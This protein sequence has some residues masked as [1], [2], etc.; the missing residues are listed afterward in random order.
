M[1]RKKKE[2][3]A[4]PHNSENRQTKE[5]IEILR[6]TGGDKRKEGKIDKIIENL[7]HAKKVNTCRRL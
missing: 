6:E 4:I 3:T 2:K 5:E 1:K 7:L